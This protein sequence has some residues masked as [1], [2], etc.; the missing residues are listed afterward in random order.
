MRGRTPT[1]PPSCSPPS[2]HGRWGQ[3][4]AV[5]RRSGPPRNRSHR[6]LPPA[7]PHHAEAVKAVVDRR[8]LASLPPPM[9]ILLARRSK[10]AT[11][12]SHCALW[13]WQDS[14]LTAET[15]LWREADERREREGG[16]RE[17]EGQGSTAI[18]RLNAEPVGLAGGG[19][20]VPLTSDH[21]GKSR[22]GRACADLRFLRSPRFA[23]V[24][25][26]LLASARSPCR[27]VVL[28][29]ER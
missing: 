13:G 12:G 4:C 20:G 6:P 8:A 24:C 1:Q 3:P 23:R 21:R 17:G 7:L 29:R 25:Q 10:A 9:A 18:G 26:S 16:K 11:I 28:E 5:P 27:A 14:L 15:R 19:N 22:P 2:M